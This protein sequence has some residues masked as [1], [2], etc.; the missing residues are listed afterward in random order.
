MEPGDLT[1]QP[2]VGLHRSTRAKSHRVG[3]RDTP[4]IESPKAEKFESHGKN[5]VMNRITIA[6]SLLS[7]RRHYARYFQNGIKP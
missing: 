5:L 7:R 3:P 1:L 6:G 4:P 2:L